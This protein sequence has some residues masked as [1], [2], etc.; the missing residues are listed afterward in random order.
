MARFRETIFGK[1][2]GTKMIKMAGKIDLKLVD[3]PE[4]TKLMFG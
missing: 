3:K 2:K 1:R 4:N